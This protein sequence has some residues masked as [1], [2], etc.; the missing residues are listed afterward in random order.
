M[1][2]YFEKLKAF[3]Q[4]N[5]KILILLFILKTAV[6]IGI[7]LVI[8]FKAKDAKAQNTNSLIR[9]GNKSYEQEKYNE[10]TDKYT[11]A[12]TKEPNNEKALF[13]Q[14]NAMYQLGEYEKA[15]TYF[16]AISKQ[17]KNIDI[18]AKAFHNLGNTYYK[19]EQYEKSVQAYKEALKLN[20]S[21]NDTKYNL[22]MALAKLK[23]EQNNQNQKDKQQ[24]NQ[25][26][27]QQQQQAKSQ[28]P[29]NKTKQAEKMSNEEAQQLLEALQNAESKTQE[30]LQQQQGSSKKSKPTK[31]W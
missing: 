5:K 27:Q 1:K 30:K 29:N 11:T 24:Q 6:K 4:R 16:D 21:D 17:S 2:K 3:A 20:P 22:M 9:S 19:Q 12:L 10:A 13:N 7:V 31:D 8:F 18:R 28:Q 25:Q 26:Q 14:A 15:A 23:N